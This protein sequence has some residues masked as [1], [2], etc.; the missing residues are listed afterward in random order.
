MSGHGPDAASFEKA[1]NADVSKPDHIVG[2][3]AFMFETRKVIHPTAQALNSPQ[4]QGNYYEC[5]R[6]LKKHFDPSKR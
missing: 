5:W 3:M 2:T 6:G 1:S 4:L